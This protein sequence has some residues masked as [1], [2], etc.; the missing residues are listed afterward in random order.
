LSD[1]RLKQFQEN[2]GASTT[3]PKIPNLKQFK[4][5]DGSDVVKEE[6][7]RLNKL[8]ME[9]VDGANKRLKQITHDMSRHGD[10]Q[11]VIDEEIPLLRTFRAELA[12]RSSM[13][14]DDDMMEYFTQQFEGPTPSRATYATTPSQLYKST[15]QILP[16]S[17]M[18]AELAEAKTV[19]QDRDQS[20]AASSNRTGLSELSVALKAMGGGSSTIQLTPSVV[21]ST[22]VLG[23]KN[24]QRQ[25]EQTVITIRKSEIVP[26]GQVLHVTAFL[27]PYTSKKVALVQALQT[28]LID[29]K[30]KTF[31]DPSTQQRMSLVQAAKKGYIDEVVLKQ[32]T[33]PCGSH[34]PQTG[35]E[36]SLLEAI[37]KRLYHPLSNTFT[38]A[39]T[40]E[41]VSVSEAVARGILSESCSRIL[42]GEKVELVSVTHAQALF[43]DSRPQKVDWGLSLGQV[44]EKGLYSEITGK[45][46]EPLSGIDTSILEAIERGY[47]NPDYE[48]IED[49]TS[50]HYITLTQAVA[51]EIVDPYRGTYNHEASNQQLPLSVAMN[52]GLVK[53][54]TSLADVVSQGNITE[55]EH[56]FDP[57]SAQVMTFAEAVDKGVISKDKKCILD[58]NTDSVLSIR[59][60]ISKGNMTPSGLIVNPEDN[61]QLSILEALKK[62]VVKLVQEDVQFS[63]TGVKDPRTSEVVTLSDA[64]KRGIVTPQ[65][66]Y[67]DS[68]TGR[69]MS[70]QQAGSSGLMDRNLVTDLNKPTSMT[71]AQGRNISVV[72]ALRLGLVDIDT[73]SVLNA[74]TRERMTVQ[75][76]ASVGL[77]TAT[78][79]T[80]VLNLL[81][82][83]VT[84]T[85]VLTQIEIPHTT[86][87]LTTSQPVLHGY[88]KE[89]KKNH[90]ESVQNNL[91]RLSSEQSQL[92]TLPSYVD[93]MDSELKKMTQ[94]TF[95][96]DTSGNKTRTIPIEPGSRKFESSY[97]TR[98]ESHY[99][100]TTTTLARPL[101]IPSVISE[102]REVNLKSVLDPRT[103]REL[104]IED[105]IKRRLINMDKGQYTHPVTGE[106]M[107]LNRAIER[108]FIKAEQMVGS[109]E[110]GPIKETRAFSIV[111]VLHPETGKRMTVSQAVSAGVLDLEKGIYNNP[112][113]QPQSMKISEAIEKGYVIVE[114]IG[115]SFAGADSMLRETKSY[116]LKTV[117]HPISGKHMSIAEA[118]AE[119]IIN[120]SEGFYN[121]LS[122]GERIPIHEA[123]EKGFIFAQLTSVKT[124]VD[125][126]VN[127]ITTTKLTTLSVTAVVHPITGQLISVSRA[128]E[129]G[130]L[131]QNKGIYTNPQTGESMTL[132]D[133]IDKRLVLAESPEARSD[134]PLERAEV[135]SIHITDE[136][137]SLE[138]NMREDIH[139]ETVTMSIT[140]VID[141]K[142]MDMI[143]YD[144]AVRSGVLNVKTGTYNNPSSRE[145]M[146]ITA[147]M[148][149]G[150]IHGEV[151]SKRR[152]DDIMRSAVSSAL[153]L[154]SLRD[155][156]SVI[157]PR[158]GKEISLETALKDGI[159]NPDKGTYFN[160]KT[161]TEIDLSKAK[162]FGYLLES[163]QSS[164]AQIEKSLEEEN[165]L[166]TQLSTPRMPRE[167]KKPWSKV[168]M[169]LEKTVTHDESA[170]DESLATEVVH[171]SSEVEHDTPQY[172]PGQTVHL[173]GSRAL[174][175]RSLDGV[176]YTDAVKLGMVHS[177]S[178]RVRDP[179]S[180]ELLT[181]QEAVDRK[182]INPNLPA[183]EEPSSG[184]TM[185]LD[186]C[187]KTGLLNP[188]VCKFDV[189]RVQQAGFSEKSLPQGAEGSTAINII[190]AV[191]AGLFNS[192]TGRFLEPTTGHRYTLQEGVHRGFID[193]QMVTVKETSSGQRLPVE[194]ALKKGLINGNTAEVYDS[195]RRVKVAL[196][197]AI[198][199][200]LVE[201][202]LSV[203][204]LSIT[205][206]RTGQQIPL[207]NA[208]V[209]GGLKPGSVVVVDTSCGEQ[210][211][212]E[213][214]L[215]RGLVDRSGFVVDKQS[216]RKMAPEEALK[217]GLMAIAG[218]PIMAGK[219]VVDAA[220]HRKSS[221]AKIP[222]E[223][224]EVVEE[225]KRSQTSPS[226]TVF[227]NVL[228]SD[229]SSSREAQTARDLP[230]VNI[231][232]KQDSH[233]EIMFPADPVVDHSGDHITYSTA[234]SSP[235]GTTVFSQ[236]TPEKQ[237][238]AT[239]TT[240]PKGI[241]TSPRPTPERQLPQ[242]FTASAKG[243][244]VSSQHTSST[245]RG[246]VSTQ[247]PS[248]RQ[249]AKISVA[250]SATKIS[251]SAKNYS[252]VSET[253]T[254][255]ME[256]RMTT[257]DGTAESHKF[258]EKL[259]TSRIIP[260]SSATTADVKITSERPDGHNTDFRHA[261][262]KNLQINWETGTVIDTVRGQKM[263]I[264]E[265]VQKGL[266]NSDIVEDL[267]SHSTGGVQSIPEIN[268]N[269]E[270]GTVTDLS[271]G[272][273]VSVESA[274]QK[275]LI[276]ASTA[277]VLASVSEMATELTTV[278]TLQTS[279]SAEPYT[280]NYATKEGMYDI[281][282][283]QIIDLSGARLSVKE[284][285]RKNIID[286][287]KSSVVD[288]QS[289]RLLSLNSAIVSN[290]F[291]PL[292]GELI[293]KTSGER[294]SL[295][296]AGTLG[297]IPDHAELGTV[298]P[299]IASKNPLSL[300][301]AVR[302]GCIDEENDT[303]TDPVTNE[304]MSL[305]AAVRYEPKEKSPTIHAVKKMVAVPKEA[306]MIVNK[307]SSFKPPA[308]DNKRLSFTEA[309]DEGLINLK[310]QQY[311]D[312]SSGQR[313]ALLDA[314]R[315]QLIDT[316]PSESGDRQGLTVPQAVE[317]GLFDDRKGVFHD[318]TSGESLSF[319]DAVD[320]GMIDK[321]FTVYDVKTGE[322]YS[323]EEGLE[324]GKIDPVTGRFIDEKSGRKLTL[325]EATQLGLLAVVGAPFA[326]AVAA[327]ES[328]QALMAG[329]KSPVPQPLP[330]SQPALSF[331]ITSAKQLS[332]NTLQVTVLKQSVPD[333]T[334]SDAMKLHEAISSG[335][336]NPKTGVFTDPVSNRQMQVSD[337]IM[338]DLIKKDSAIIRDPLTGT[339][340]NLEEALLRGV[341]DDVGC[342][343]DS[344][345]GQARNLDQC[346]KDGIVQESPLLTAGTQIFSKSTET[347]HVDSVYDPIAKQDISLDSAV[348]RNII[349]LE[350][351]TYENSATGEKMPI[352]EAISEDLVS[353]KVMDKLI[354]VE[355]MTTSGVT[356]EVAFLEK[357]SLQINS[358]KDPTTG[359]GVSL[360]EAV[361]RGIIDEAGKYFHDVTTG[362]TV[363]LNDA[364]QQGLVSATTLKSH[365]D[366]EER[367]QRSHESVLTQSST[368]RI[369]ALVDP[370]T[371]SQIPLSQAIKTGVLDVSSGTLANTRTGEAM[372]LG[373]ALKQGLLKGD[374]GSFLLTDGTDL[375]Q[376][377]EVFDSKTGQQVTFSEAIR[378]GINDSQGSYISTS[379]NISVGFGEQEGMSTKQT[380]MKS[381][382]FKE[383]SCDISAVYDPVRDKFVNVAEAVSLGLLDLK[384]GAYN[385]PAS[386]DPIPLS[387]AFEEGLIK[388]RV[389][390]GHS[391]S[392]D[393]YIRSSSDTFRQ[394]TKIGQDIL[395][396]ESPDKQRRH[397]L[398][399]YKKEPAEPSVDLTRRSF[400]SSQ[401]EI[402]EPVVTSVTQKSM[403]ITAVVDPASGREL[404]MSEAIGQGVFDPD[405]GVIINSKTGEHIQ[406]DRAI[407][408]GLVS[409]EVEEEERAQEVVI[410]SDVLIT[411]VKDPQTGKSI[412]VS[413]A[414]RR[415]IL[416]KDTGVYNHS[417]GTVSVKEALKHGLV[418]GKD[419]SEAGL[420]D[421]NKQDA[422]QIN[423]TSVNDPSSGRRLGLEEAIER[424][425]IDENCTVFNDPVTG[426]QMLMEDAMKEGL[427]TGSIQTV[428]KSQTTVTSKKAAGTY[429]ITA[430]LDTGTGQEVSVVEAISKGI[431][432]PSGKYTDPL[433]GDVISLAE[434]MNQGLVIS[435]KIEKSPHFSA[436]PGGAG[437]VTF[438][439]AL[440]LGLVDP[441]TGHFLEHASQKMY[442]IDDAVRTGLVVA[443]DG[444]PF[445][446][447]ELS[448]AGETCSITTALQTGKIDMKTCLFY[449]NLTGG[450]ISLE[451]ALIEGYLSPVSGLQQAKAIR[452]SFNIYLGSNIQ[453]LPGFK[454]GD[455]RS[456]LESE[457]EDFVSVLRTGSSIFSDVSNEDFVDSSDIHPG[458]SR[459][460]FKQRLQH[461]SL[462][463]DE[464]GSSLL[465]NGGIVTG[466]H[467][468]NTGVVDTTSA[469][470]Q[471]IQRTSPA[472]FSD[473]NSFD[474]FSVSQTIERG[475]HEPVQT[476]ETPEEYTSEMQ[477]ASEEFRG[478]LQKSSR[479]T[480]SFV[481][482]KPAADSRFTSVSSLSE[483]QKFRDNLTPGQKDLE[484]GITQS[485]NVEYTST[486]E[487]ASFQVT[488]FEDQNTLSQQLDRTFADSY[489][490][491]VEDMSAELQKLQ[492][493]E[494]LLKED[495]E[496]EDGAGRLQ[497]QLDAHKALHEEILACQQP[498]SSLI[499]EAEQ[500][501]ELYQEELT[502]EEVTSLS[503][504]AANLQKVLEKVVKTSDRRLRHLKTA[505]EELF[506]LETEI[507]SFKLQE[508]H[509]KL[510]NDVQ[511]HQATIRAMSL[512]VQKYMDE[513]KLYKL[514][515]DSF[516][517]DRQRPVRSSLIS[518]DC[519]A[520]EVVKDQ[521]KEVSD[522]F[523]NLKHNRQA[524]TMSPP[525]MLSWLADVEAEL[526]AIQQ[527]CSNCSIFFT[528][529]FAF[530]FAIISCVQ[531]TEIVLKYFCCSYGDS[532]ESVRHM[533]R[534]L[535]KSGDLDMAKAL[536]QQ[537]ADIENQ[538]QK[539]HETCNR[540]TSSLKETHDKLGTFQEKLQATQKWFQS[541]IS[542]L[543]SSETNSLP[544]DEVRD[545]VTSI[546]VE[547]RRKEADIAELK[548]LAKEL[549]EDSGAG[550][551]ASLNKAIAELENAA[552]QLDA[553]VEERQAKTAQREKQG[554]EFEL[555][556]TVMLLWLAQME[557]RMDEF[558]PAAVTA[559]IVEK[560]ILE[561]Q[562]MLKEYEDHAGKVDQVNDIGNALEAL[563][564]SGDQPLS[565]IRHLGR[566]RN[567]SGLAS[568]VH[569]RTPSPTYPLS[570]AAMKTSMSSES[571]GISSR[572]SSSD[573]LLLDDLSLTQQ[574]LLDVNQRYEIIG[575]RLADRQ[576]ELQSIL[577]H[578]STFLQDMQGIMAWLE[579]KEQEL[580]KSGALGIPANEK[581]V[582]A[583]LM[584]HEEFHQELLSKES[585]VEETRKRAL[586]LLKSKPGAPGLNSLQSQ[587]THL[588]EKWHELRAVS[589]ERRKG[590]EDAVS[591]LRDF[592][593]HE[594]Q[595]IKWFGQKEK[596]MNVLGPVAMEQSLLRSQME[597][598]QVLKEEF[599]AQEPVYEQFLNSGHAI[600]EWCDAN[601]SDS[602]AV[603]KHMDNI[604]KSWN[605][606][607]ELQERFPEVT[608]AKDL[609]Q[610][611]CDSTKDASTKA[612][613]R[614]KMAALDKDVSDTVKKLEARAGALEDASKAGEEFTAKCQQMLKWIKTTSSIVMDAAALTCDTDLLQ[615]QTL[616]NKALRQDLSVKEDDIHHLLEKGNKFIR[617]ASPT[618][619]NKAVKEALTLLQNEWTV[620]KGEV[621]KRKDNIEAASA[622]AVVFQQNLDKISWWLGAAEEK[623]K[624]VTPESLDKPAIIVKLKEL[625]NLQNDLLRKSHDHDVFNKTAASL[626]ESVEDPRHELQSQVAEVNR[627]WDS[628]TL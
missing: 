77:I 340:L 228:Q 84:T 66:S 604:T 179:K 307:Q 234:T 147:A 558:E 508:E 258:N 321:K 578:T 320:K 184:N 176:S 538:F 390:D 142:T 278:T 469:F 203:H 54:A 378:K 518:M 241:T 194:A 459:D 277:T 365:K 259:S 169:E 123:I 374:E 163:K 329:D 467:I 546:D 601:T 199:Q 424:G 15:L 8:Y 40:G 440:K 209:N 414:V 436:D 41:Q 205:D 103:G 148:E 524:S 161:R 498:I 171:Y 201:N 1:K 35:D 25:Q 619:E 7:D 478:K 497:V 362:S 217:L 359:R 312:P 398:T 9:M 319:Q 122:T 240:S 3:Q 370:A 74:R 331:Q 100:F 421:Q 83:V 540:Q 519:E 109:Q 290:I 597:Q 64:F 120:E 224:T 173:L 182:V 450:G 50:G 223:K 419:T 395:R 589:E 98:T 530:N 460:A 30:T 466:H 253:K 502:P 227:I 76:A 573:H 609:C 446:Y 564:S 257:V 531:L 577:S 275:G 281:S 198:E 489:D 105:A 533:T 208:I 229:V 613:L 4:Q 526:S 127:K 373:D 470:R 448:K 60:A 334:A 622:N 151:T 261:S 141:P 430:V 529:F 99:S 156:T 55:D 620:L 138:A 627:R 233:Q 160:P 86:E 328:F 412:S 49:P 53:T 11:I 600:F 429:N 58:A 490:K 594:E 347:I 618:A 154:V 614:A 462:F 458:L 393:D 200:D 505:S 565:P 554:E 300:K 246:P 445:K 487:S 168:D 272:N 417:G 593:E 255:S 447:K 423:V 595:L 204:T 500:L 44:V 145:T 129:E 409:A 426:V 125:K 10:M 332:S 473:A 274:L 449:D 599:S 89:P 63:R 285:L 289:R 298:S 381:K 323:L 375:P 62:G 267:A 107:A 452:E 553:A 444:R 46:T 560:Q 428:S 451:E 422:K 317:Q 433:T 165:L 284:A 348:G 610:Q 504:E 27:N 315:D 88:V 342:V 425:L 291:D 301:E 216:G 149:K 484:F 354:T 134:D 472:A 598:V 270:L 437:Y 438:R 164:A 486:D 19:R 131:D 251:T 341:L 114:D 344:S 102:T 581:S 576:H 252:S 603:S 385:D 286:G 97:M 117:L 402:N 43:A 568:P 506:K 471:G 582:R 388:G 517:A 617:D 65:G 197:S 372:S 213:S 287:D 292:T 481:Q 295:Q 16:E 249:P 195:V 570:P 108:G 243:P 356:T 42:S 104:D 276:D 78:D 371:N 271:T 29:T 346:I 93:E 367:Y 511:S 59:E 130:I 542:Q 308:E 366:T 139:S 126:D 263:T 623:L 17:T 606:L 124:D 268:I 22:A 222:V 541:N 159:I 71:D 231:K 313:L 212:L 477:S 26:R 556:M 514:E 297:L 548:K 515:V 306:S 282:T 358:V 579:V 90:E 266:I 80:N 309:V 172:T 178:G 38:D 218:A 406:L 491:I 118:I 566:T 219:L 193:G 494:Q 67:V 215:S 207:R 482:D 416:D 112:D 516:R 82:S 400:V 327:K 384:S 51:T 584:D 265:A 394:E 545:Q 575:E 235:K 95:M 75:D 221:P 132:G 202:R 230:E 31:V 325:R 624:K 20:E 574:Q 615:K 143:S 501:T 389:S 463:V 591:D 454:P 586:D 242:D 480:S 236:P 57:V 549:Q 337:A 607:Q 495:G 254:V 521:L 175:T 405:R 192:I 352:S 61:S 190:D 557:A 47:I 119:G 420:T 567:I 220:R 583:E 435:E 364:I 33:S 361:R 551:S 244:T 357:K 56:I 177:D 294:I 605:K 111:G 191:S 45:V 280:L 509:G 592:R 569:Q 232:P 91:P 407:D 628:V 559:D 571:S 302:R 399:K 520:A 146:T 563:T 304:V 612:D 410:I 32:L 28:G 439:D 513:A 250:S 81:S 360:S 248:E 326:A 442:S 493:F 453:G 335:Y 621:D 396:S 562:P 408:L 5:Q 322:I 483:S 368:F 324:E 456:L 247:W 318:F 625:R 140:S 115:E 488:F 550:S 464:N 283:G 611:L 52:K 245:K 455:T 590:L 457:K 391:L 353:G 343:V 12:K 72:E 288:P 206:E 350:D 427:I 214:A 404:L 133:A 279:S 314:I 432:D 311:T 316:S 162:E 512:S 349:D 21:A 474:T 383:K 211:P 382:T 39:T 333:S 339:S 189:S 537:I 369:H 626:L 135:S 580:S 237:S 555:A 24:V 379:E 434:A 167:S 499:Y 363:S 155:I 596:L 181:L 588:D 152:E 543:Q 68:R 413:E 461:D 330:T 547:R 503:G 397:A 113:A 476:V 157:D 158:T 523:S 561:L 23:A 522:D 37:N 587:L 183:L 101:L 34:D 527:D 602:A 256:S 69:E 136:Q 106:S 305:A 116:I 539:V 303:F 144:E 296:E 14:V 18:T 532:I 210:V 403:T 238:P 535:I 387:Q 534:N 226:R 170:E 110:G 121:R 507:A 377:K 355:E 293:H 585:L 338:S 401:P 479:I 269:W 510:L 225:T 6:L 273:N 496:M 351:G 525:T 174:P 166:E 187:L 376:H 85:T 13:L 262:L 94:E 336:L 380:I 468:H 443:S 73:G 196:P 188:Q 411:D 36:L 552:A 48:E 96:T 239:S 2:V 264:P 418:N 150:L 79:A 536:E 441:L 616:E 137:E 528:L 485:S 392:K 572:K 345:T 465:E 415:G 544:V 70:L 180:G 608:R 260:I 153:P 299:G 475:L 92:P 185:S 386:L 87:I 310:E 492:G 431:L 186:V 128:V